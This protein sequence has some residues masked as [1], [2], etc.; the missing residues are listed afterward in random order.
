MALGRSLVIRMGPEWENQLDE[1]NISKRG[2]PFAYPDLLMGGIAYIRHVLGE[3]LRVI[4][5]HVDAMLG[6]R[7]KG[8]DHVTIWRRTCAQAV[9]MQDDRITI[10]MTTG[11]THVLVAGHIGTTTTSKGR[12][13]ELKRNVKCN[14][15]K[16]HILADEESQKILAF[17][18]T[19]ASGCD[20]K[21]LCPG[22]R[23]I[24]QRGLACRWKTAVQ[25]R[26]CP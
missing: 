4:E 17:R 24:P 11:K 2:R 23:N 18:I 26:R 5:G 1:M 19:D 13:I 15:I 8:P 20:A 7:M 12:R 25:N 6:K 21:N 10:R 14:F 22:C 16:L 3:G 9:S